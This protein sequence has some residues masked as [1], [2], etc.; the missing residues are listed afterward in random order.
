MTN[1]PPRLSGIASTWPQMLAPSAADTCDCLVSGYGHHPVLPPT[2]QGVRCVPQNDSTPGF[3]RRSAMALCWARPWLLPWRSEFVRRE[4]IAAGETD[5]GSHPGFRI[6]ASAGDR[7]GRRGG[8]HWRTRV[9]RTATGAD[10]VSGEAGLPCPSMGRGTC[11]GAEAGLRGRATSGSP[12]RL[13]RGVQVARA[14]F[15]SY[16]S[17]QRLKRRGCPFPIVKFLRQSEKRTPLIL[18]KRFQNL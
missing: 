11:A 8:G 7:R 6:L 10:P 2:G 12:C 4:K 13:V 17:T 14:A 15:P 18:P 16:Q 3:R 9:V 5:P 1:I